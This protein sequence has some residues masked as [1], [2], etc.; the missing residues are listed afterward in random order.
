MF[1][2]V[3]RPPHLYTVKADVLRLAEEKEKEK[4]ELLQ[5]Q[6]EQALQEEEEARARFEEEA[7]QHLA[8]EERKTQ[9]A[10]VIAHARCGHSVP[11]QTGGRPQAHPMPCPTHLHCPTYQ[12]G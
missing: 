2:S 12:A 3:N 4:E 9:A 6:R 1:I 7:A 8:D 5:R 10:K 11:T